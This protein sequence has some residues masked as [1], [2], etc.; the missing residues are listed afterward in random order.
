[1]YE[2]LVHYY[3]AFQKY[4]RQGN[5]LYMTDWAS[6]DNSP[7]NPYLDKGGTAVDTSSQMVLFGNQL[8]EIADLLGRRTSPAFRKEAAELAR[9]INEKMWDSKRKFYFDL[10]ADGKQGPA[11]TVAAFWTLLAGVASPEQADALAA[12]L[13]NSQSF[14]RKH[15]VRALPPTRRALIRRAAIG[16]VPSGRPPT[17]CRSRLESTQ[18]RSSPQDR[19]GAPANGR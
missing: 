10:T 13:C 3:R 16:A 2:P 11:K 19:L 4:V 8:A 6:M 7:R 1:V 5:G 17:R 12:E 9:I 14:G 18:A 15:R